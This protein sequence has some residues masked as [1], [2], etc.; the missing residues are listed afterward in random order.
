MFPGNALSAGMV[1]SAVETVLSPTFP[2][3]WT[4]EIIPA[5]SQRSIFQPTSP[6][7]GT[8]PATIP[9]T[10][11]GWLFQ[12]TSPVRGTTQGADRIDQIIL[13]ST[14]VPRA[15]D[16]EAWNRRANDDRNYFNPRPPCGGRPRN[17]A[18]SVSG[19]INF[20]PRP[21]HGGRRMFRPHPQI[22]IRFQPTSPVRGTTVNHIIVREPLR[23][24][25]THVPRTGDDIASDSSSDF[26]LAFQPT[27]PV[28]GTTFY[29]RY[30]VPDTFHISTHVPRAGDDLR[31][32][33]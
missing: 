17:R 31:P 3:W 1:P 7:R 30:G 25:S 12:P 28:R 24:I 26:T 14:H 20:N 5:T 13:I 19:I 6:V 9:R 27:S 2:V 10:T 21:P 8:T 33:R 22:C 23:V 11:G 29:V 32:T 4:T 16:D 15:G 18:G